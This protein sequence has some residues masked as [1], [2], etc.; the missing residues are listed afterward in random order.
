ML[1][2]L[3]IVMTIVCWGAYGPLLHWGQSAMD[4]GRLRPF[5]CVG[6]AYFLVAIVVPMIMM[7]MGVERQMPWRFTG[8]A[9]SL[10]AG[11]AGAV[12]ALGIILAISFRG[13]PLY[14]MPLVFGGA[15]V[16]NTLIVITASRQWGDVNP[17]FYAGL[18][19]VGLGA[20]TV[21]IAKP[22]SRPHSTASAIS[23]QH[24]PAPTAA[25]PADHD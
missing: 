15:P 23:A 21:L 24:Q 17:F 6:I 4:G 19:L 14:I 12:G 9:W 11:I 10:A 20:V 18:L 13:D 5:M 8:V 3:S 16:I 1:C 25:A 7:G 2:V 22:S